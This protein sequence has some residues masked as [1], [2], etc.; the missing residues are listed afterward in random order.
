MKK[1][2]SDREI[3]EMQR[4]IDEGIVLA[5]KRLVEHS[6]KLGSTLVVSRNGKVVELLA[7]E[8]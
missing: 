4:L 2:M 8:L 5:Q 3:K 7:D 1:A 6:R